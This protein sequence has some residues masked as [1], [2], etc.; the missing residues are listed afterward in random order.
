MVLWAALGVG[1][2]AAAGA[3]QPADAGRQPIRVVIWDERQPAQKSVYPNFLGN[4]LA[5][6]LRN[7]ERGRGARL[8]VRSVGIDDPEQGLSSDVLDNCDVLVWWGHQRHGEISAD[9]AKGIVRRITSGQLSLIALHS[10][11]WSRPFIEAMNER[12]TRDALKSLTRRERKNVQISYIPPDMRLMRKDEKLTPW[13]T[14]T[15]GANGTTQL[16]IK[17]PSCVF[18]A[19]RADAKPSHVR[20]LAKNHPIA[21]GVPETFDISQ[22]EMYDEPFHV[23]TPDAV[24]FEERWDAGERFRGGCLWNLGAGKVFYFR[25]GHETYPVFKEAAPLRLVENA[26]RWMGKQSSSNNDDDY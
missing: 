13:W 21:R 19:V 2:A 7:S 17:L 23:P 4:H 14:K 3:G 24:I 10:A 18:P 16:Q 5:E 25:P 8:Q 22:T 20:I 15:A 12:S 11:H 9:T 1:L 26:V 6:Y